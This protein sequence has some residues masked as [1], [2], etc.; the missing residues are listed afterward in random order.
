V[1]R[2]APGQDQRAV[3]MIRA[4]RT[5]GVVVSLVVPGFE[6]LVEIGRGGNAVVY[7]ARQVAVDR[8]VAVK[9]I[10]RPDLDEAERRRFEREAR[11]AGSLSWHPHVVAV[12]DAGILEAGTPYLVMELLPGGSLADRLRATGPLPWT[13]A[14]A[15]AIQLATALEVAHREGMLHR[16]VKPG[17]A[18]VTRLGDV[19]LGDFG[20]AVAQGS[21]RTASGLVVATIAHAPPEV[22]TAGEVDERADVY[23]LGSTLYELLAGRPPFVGDTDESPLATAYRTVHEP[24]PELDPQLAP[25]GVR[26]LVHRCLAKRPDDRPASALAVALE[27]HG[28]ELAAGLPGTP[29]R[30]DDAPA[31]GAIPLGAGVAAP[32]VAPASAR[33]APPTAAPASAAATGSSRGSGPSPSQAG[34]TTQALVLDDHLVG[35][36]AGAAAAAVAVPPAPVPVTEAPVPVTEA[37]VPVTEAPVALV[38]P[39]PPPSEAGAAPAVFVP[40]VVPATRRENRGRRRWALLAALV[41][42]VV[43]AAAAVAAFVA[44]DPDGRSGSGRE[45]T[46]TTSGPSSTASTTTGATTTTGAGGTIGGGAPAAGSGQTGTS[47]L[48][49]AEPADEVTETDPATTAAPTGTRPPTTRTTTSSTPTTASTTATP[50]TDSTSDAPTTDPPTTASPTTTTPTTAATTTDPPTTTT[51]ATSEQPITPAT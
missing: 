5:S 48:S 14:V 10:A 19:K 27:L 44:D 29:I 24:L 38:G 3:P 25:A 40:P 26:S 43:L 34:G 35:P 47:A 23:S 50:T 51:A 15:A 7:R 4:D 39:P 18:L 37:P 49:D 16:D 17:N 30:V 41:V 20:I 8:E 45:S 31:T 12:H 32:A 9:V 33:L 2:A 42:G 28:N 22:L 36:G 21:T 1:D 11:L 46:S 6:D 13:D